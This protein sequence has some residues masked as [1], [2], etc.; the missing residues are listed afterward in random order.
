MVTAEIKADLD[1][2]IQSDLE[3]IVGWSAELKAAAAE[4]DRARRKSP[5]KERARSEF[6]G[7]FSAADAD[8]DSLLNLAEFLDAAER[9]K[10][11]KEERQEPDTERTEAQSVA[12]Y[13]AI[14]KI[15]P[16]V[17][18]ISLMDLVVALFYY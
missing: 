8:G 10:K 12:Y 11:A 13:T 15:N 14:N 17:D 16:E 9:F 7:I 3:Q 1:P 5:G 4:F 6:Q 18:G 2:L